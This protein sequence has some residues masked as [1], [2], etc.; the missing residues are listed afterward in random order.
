MWNVLKS[1][2]TWFGHIINIYKSKQ[3]TT[4]FMSITPISREGKNLY[5]V[6]VKQ[7]LGE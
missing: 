2:K 6:A 4:E 5:Y 1:G 7:L 3:K